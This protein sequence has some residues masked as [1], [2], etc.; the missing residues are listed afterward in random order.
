MVW[1]RRRVALTAVGA[2]V[3]VALAAGGIAYAIHHGT[4]G[5]LALGPKPAP[6]QSAK[7]PT[8]PLLSPFT[9]EPVHRLSRVGAQP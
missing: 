3:V 5:K 4:A 1:D 7:P 9:G 6:A 2:A 8:G